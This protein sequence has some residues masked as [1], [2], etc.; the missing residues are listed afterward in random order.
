MVS[1]KSFTLLVAKRNKTVFRICLNNFCERL[2]SSH[3]KKT[4]KIIESNLQKENK[5]QDNFGVYE[6]KRDDK[7][8]IKGVKKISQLGLTFVYS[9][10]Y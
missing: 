7:I 4:I 8:E 2:W 1:K 10:S 5:N 6:N 3:V 9:R